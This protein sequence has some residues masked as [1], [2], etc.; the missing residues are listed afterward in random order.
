MDQDKLRIADY[1]YDRLREAPLQTK[2]ELERY[3]RQSHAN[4]DFKQARTDAILAGTFGLTSIVAAVA[5]SPVLLVTVPFTAYFAH[6]AMTER[7][8]ALLHATSAT[9]PDSAIQAIIHKYELDHPPTI[10][11]YAEREGTLD[12]EP[13]LAR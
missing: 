9:M 11:E 1:G 8:N 2:I 7:D 3:C 4:T 6:S 10:I 13:A 12:E 5:A